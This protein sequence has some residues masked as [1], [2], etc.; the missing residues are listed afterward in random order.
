[1]ANI[2]DLPATA[3]ANLAR[4]AELVGVS[5]SFIS[6]GPARSETILVNNPFREAS[7]G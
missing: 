3:Q 7:A 4:I 2:E 5:L 1:V 6:W